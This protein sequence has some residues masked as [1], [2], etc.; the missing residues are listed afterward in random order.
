ME[1]DKIKSYKI[2]SKVF[3]IKYGKGLASELLKEE[4]SIYEETKLEPDVILGINDNSFEKKIL[5]KNPSIHEEIENG[6]S[7]KF[8]ETEI[9]WL[10]KGEK[11]Y[12]NM[13]FDEN[14][15]N[16]LQKLM[17]IQYT[18]PFENIG[19]IFHELVLIP[20]LFFYPADL[21]I[22]HGSALETKDNK[23]IIIAGTG[24]VGK[25]SLELSLIFKNQSKFLSDDI[26][27]VDKNCYI[28][29]NYSFPKIYG[30]NTIGKKNL[31]QRIL[32]KRSAFDKIQWNFSKIFLNRPIRRRVNPK[33]FYNDKI[34]KGLELTN[35]YF[36]FRGNYSDFSFEN[37]SAETAAKINIEIIKTEYSAFLNHLHWHKTNRLAA[38]EKIL[39]DAEQVLSKWH[40]LQKNILGQCKCYLLK[41]P[42]NAEISEIEKKFFAF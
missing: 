18:H 32:E 7:C 33:V 25:T 1:N 35:Y 8:G 2:A 16:F 14:K 17:S 21:S 22:I 6:F 15:K 12:I 11:I 40:E 42:L 5:S 10:K 29:P 30:Y 19:Q 20:T 38:K 24:G 34:S 41:I 13:V 27:F 9:S 36:L 4:L 39:I 3:T 26:V 28:H 37:I 31:E 23:A